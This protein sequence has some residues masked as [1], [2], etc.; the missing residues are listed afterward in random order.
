MRKSPGTVDGWIGD[1]FRNTQS[2]VPPTP[3]FR[4][5][6]TPS[7]KRADETT[8]VAREITEAAKERLQA[9]VARLR[10]ARLEKEAV[11]RANAARVPAKKRQASRSR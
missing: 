4:P 8:R 2:S 10:Q 5:T 11:D 6:Q 9:D 7:E 1:I 3:A